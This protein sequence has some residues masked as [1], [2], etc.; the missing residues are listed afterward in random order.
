MKRIVPILALAAALHAED[1]LTGYHQAA[2]SH[3]GPGEWRVPVEPVWVYAYPTLRL[4]Y[5]ARG[6][7]QSD[8][9]VLTLRPGSVGPVTP[10]ATNPENP[11]VAGMPVP[12][13]VARH[14]VAD[15]ARHTVEIDLRGKLRTPQIDELRFAVPPSAHIDIESLEFRGTA[16][17]LPCDGGLPL[18]PHAT[19]LAVTGGA[20]CGSSR[21]TSLRGKET[22]LVAGDRRPGRTLYLSLFPHFANVAMFA[23]G[24]DPEKTRVKDS[25]ET[26]DFL[27]RLH[28]TDGAVEEQYPLSVESRRHLLVNRKPAL[29]T[30]ELDPARPLASAELMDRSPHAQFLLHFAA[31]SPEAGPQSIEEFPVSTIKRTRPPAAPDF[32]VSYRI[33]GAPPDAIQASLTNPNTPDGHRA[34]LE[35]KNV[36]AEAREFTLTFPAATIRPGGP[37]AGIYYLF[38]RQGAVIASE[39]RTLEA[40]YNAA[41][42]LQFVDVFSPQANSGAAVVV[43]DTTARGKTFRLRKT[44]PAVDVEIDYLVRLG[45]GETWRP[46]QAQITAHGGDWHEGFAVYRK[47]LASWYKPLGPRPAWL[48][49]AFW[50]RRDYPV[51]GTGKLFDVRH[52]RYTYDRLLSDGRAFGGIDFIDISGWAMSDKAGRVGDYPIELGGVDDLR[53]NVSLGLKDGIPTGLYF[54]GYLIDKRSKVGLAQDGRWQLI[55]KKGQGA[56]WTGGDPTE[57]FVCPYVPEWQKYLSRR[58]AAVARDTSA[59]GV[60]LDEFG[61]GRMRCYSADHGHPVGVE[62]MAGEIQMA[63]TVRQALAAA[64][65]QDTMLYIEETPPDAAAPY[66]DAAFCYNFPNADL[67]LS[68]LKLNL[69]RFA[70][71]DIRLWD[72]L[73]IGIDPRVL[74]QEDFRLSL[75][76]GNGLWLKG[77]SET[78]YGD[79]LMQLIRRARTLLR[80]H[81]AAF[82]GPAEPLIESP[83]PAVFINRFGQGAQT[84]YTLF[85]AS[86]RTA[87]FRFQGQERVL[88]PRDVDVIAAN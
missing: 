70:F 37:A 34:A 28:Y 46:P 60:Y 4:T 9:A 18:P 22:L 30:V 56:W 81:S 42:P 61:F 15:N 11:F 5:R 48:R 24:R 86:Y 80:S 40:P 2:I 63:K 83:H 84:V 31:I 44:G 88:A 49:T 77:H 3:A 14:L 45:P 73:S 35:V 1:L 54:E 78:W 79:D 67:Q 66:Y 74:P 65:R 76:H 19:R 55:D 39:D 82:A 26:A 38:P 59:D 7:P 58:V 57:L 27:V 71:P 23:A 87:R 47:W 12:V 75:W 51:G 25:H 10:G 29:Y 52:G 72:M 41:F 20:G 17:L 85:N 33:T 62:T 36:S 68:P 21:G 16:E 6:L 64:G 69:S 13:V 32:T 8:F 43:R 53:R 50:A